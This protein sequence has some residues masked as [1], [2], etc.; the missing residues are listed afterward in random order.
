MKNLASLKVK[1]FADGADKQGMLQLNGNPLIKGLTTNP[2][3]MRK[4]GITQFETFARDILQHIT[5]KPVSFEVFSDEFAEMKRQALLINSWAHNVY[6]KIPITNTRRE[7]SL[8]LIRE[9]A[10]EGV[11]LNITAILTLDQ[12]AGTIQALNPQVPSFVSV[13]AGRIADTGLDPV[14]E[15]RESRKLMADNPKAELLWASVREV[16]NIYQAEECGCDIVTV[17][18]DIL[19]KAIKLSGMNLADLSL[20]T[21]KMFAADAQAA[22]FTL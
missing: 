7:S 5:V 15:M 16:L 3:L 8:P 11:K 6:V 21:V 20:D 12:V 17:P 1:I 4:A 22:G 13:F 10:H 19:N 2:T 9:L 18:H 14:P